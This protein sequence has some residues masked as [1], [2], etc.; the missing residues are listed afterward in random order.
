MGNVEDGQEGHPL[1][2]RAPTY[3]YPQ[4][5]RLNFFR[6]TL[7]YVL[8]SCYFSRTARL[9]ANI[10]TTSTKGTA[11]RRVRIRRLTIQLTTRPMLTGFLIM[12]IGGNEIQGLTAFGQCLMYWIL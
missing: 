8:I 12:V 7:L 2:E 4:F 6:F 1:V 11:T 5:V 3:D 9:P 10:Q